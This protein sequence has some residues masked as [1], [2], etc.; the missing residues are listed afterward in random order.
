LSDG[1]RYLVRLQFVLI[2][3]LSD[4][5]LALNVFFLVIL[6]FRTQALDLK[7]LSLACDWSRVTLLNDMCQFVS[8]QLLTFRIRRIVCSIA[9]ENVLPGRESN[10]IY[11]AVEFVGLSTGVNAHSLKIR[12][13]SRLHLPPH[14]MVEALPTST[15]PL[16]GRL[17]ISIHFTA[18][19]PGPCQYPLHIPVPILPLQMHN[20]SDGS[21]PL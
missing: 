16:D 8:Q 11:S 17:D 19:L 15:G 14:S 18:S 5:Q 13:E 7:T 4:R 2:V 6:T 20:G 12:T 9:E 3:R 10:G 21:R 1:L